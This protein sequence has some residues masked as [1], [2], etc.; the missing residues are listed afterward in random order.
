MAALYSRSGD[1]WVATEGE[2]L[3][4]LSHDSD[5]WEKQKGKGLPGTVNFLSLVEDRQGRIWAGTDNQGVAVWNG[6]SWM[7]YNQENA[8]LGERVPALAVS[9]LNGDVA[10]ATSGGLTIYSAETEEWKDFTR[11]NGL[12][13]D[14]IVSLSFNEQGGLWAAF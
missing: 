4:K 11:A 8:L 6:E 13:E 2:G 10:I 5:H 1:L 14:Q 7:Q 9:P 3:L 12:P